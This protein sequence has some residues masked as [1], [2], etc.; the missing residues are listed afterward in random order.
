MFWITLFFGLILNSHHCDSKAPSIFHKHLIQVKM[1]DKYSS[2]LQ[3]V[4]KLQSNRGTLSCKKHFAETP[5]TSSQKKCSTLSTP[6]KT[7]LSSSSNLFMSLPFDHRMIPQ[8]E[9]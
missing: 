5:E 7:N 4:H 8:W 2:L 3:S 9:R 6:F 1:L